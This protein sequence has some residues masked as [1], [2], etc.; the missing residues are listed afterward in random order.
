MN[1]FFLKSISKYL[2]MHRNVMSFSKFENDGKI[3]NL[4]VDQLLIFKI[5]FGEKQNHPFFFYGRGHKI[6]YLASIVLTQFGAVETYLFSA[7]VVQLQLGTWWIY[8][9]LFIQVPISHTILV[10]HTSVAYNNPAPV[11]TNSDLSNYKY[12]LYTTQCT[13][14]MA[15]YLVPKTKTVGVIVSLEAILSLTQ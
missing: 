6:S 2:K 11:Y 1:P 5:Y 3:K 13:C 8:G 12:Y 7:Q 4:S 10:S 9:N 15:T 14:P